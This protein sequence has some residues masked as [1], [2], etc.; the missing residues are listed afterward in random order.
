MLSLE[1][2]PGDHIVAFQYLKVACEK[3]GERH[4][5]KACSDGTGNNGFKLKD[6]SFD[7]EN[8][9]DI[10]KKF[11]VMGVE[12]HWNRLLRKAVDASLFEVF[13]VRLAEKF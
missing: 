5:T 8:I 9:K 6:C 1:K 3:D 12:R 7:I 2:T 11:F 13:K 10:K 4:L